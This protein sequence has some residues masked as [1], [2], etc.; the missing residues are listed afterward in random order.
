VERK[1]PHFIFQ[2]FCNKKDFASKPADCYEIY[3]FTLHP[4][5][6]MG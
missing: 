3:C 6:H 2:N 1:P 4:T 5:K